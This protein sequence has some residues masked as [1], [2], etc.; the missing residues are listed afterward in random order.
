MR[1]SSVVSVLPFYTIL[2]HDSVVRMRDEI[3]NIGVKGR[4]DDCDEIII[5]ALAICFSLSSH[6]INFGI[7]NAMKLIFVIRGV[8]ENLKRI[9]EDFLILSCSNSTHALILSFRITKNLYSQKNLQYKSRKLIKT[10]FINFAKISL[11]F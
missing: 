5:S 8:W 10:W 1:F 2:R 11:W 3:K 6:L 7:F 4:K 9:T